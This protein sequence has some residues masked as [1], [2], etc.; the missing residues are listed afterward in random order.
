MLPIF[1]FRYFVPTDD[2][3]AIALNVRL[4]PTWSTILDLQFNTPFMGLCVMELQVLKESINW[5]VVQICP[6]DLTRYLKY[7]S[8]RKIGLSY[9]NLT[10]SEDTSV[11][12]LFPVSRFSDTY[13][14]SSTDALCI[15]L[16]NVSWLHRQW[17]ALQD[18]ATFFGNKNILA[19]DK[20]R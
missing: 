20:H 17:V 7:V 4:G 13:Y 14:I 12:S 1:V 11:S 6:N 2:K 19:F 15:S 5:Y 3:T 8:T 9:K 16:F 18:P 10:R